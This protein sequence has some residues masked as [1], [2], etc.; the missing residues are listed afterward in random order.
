MTGVDGV[1]LGD[2][3]IKAGDGRDRPGVQSV[4]LDPAVELGV[5]EASRKNI[6][7]EGLG[8]DRCDVAVVTDVA[9]GEGHAQA[10]GDA[11]GGRDVEVE[12]DGE[13]D[14][15]TQLHDARDRHERVGELVGRVL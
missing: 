13:G 1:Y 7:R 8:F 5:F 12:A 4:L 6:L 2:R 3:R 10:R 9:G 15:G 14:A 11:H